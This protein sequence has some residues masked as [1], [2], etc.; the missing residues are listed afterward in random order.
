MTMLSSFASSTPRGY[1]KTIIG[2][3][4]SA[5]LLAL[6]RPQIQFGDSGKLNKEFEEG[7][8]DRLQRRLQIDVGGADHSIQHVLVIQADEETL[9]KARH[10]LEKELGLEE[11]LAALKDANTL[12]R[13]KNVT[14]DD[15]RRA[16]E[17]AAEVA[18]LLVKKASSQT[19]GN[20][21]KEVAI[22]ELDEDSDITSF[23]AC[24]DMPVAVCEQMIRK[25]LRELGL[26]WKRFKL[27]KHPKRRRDAPGYNKVVIQTDTLAETV[28]VNPDYPYKWNGVDGNRSIGPWICIGLTPE[29][30][31]NSIKEDV[32]D[33]NAADPGVYVECEITVPV[34]GEGNSDPKRIIINESTDGRV[35]EV[36][37]TG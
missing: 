12:L 26:P 22:A 20:S 30:C 14:P 6:L 9:L 27:E 19:R 7:G 37:Q 24:E 8:A 35:H 17:L 21:G 3:L 36:P 29:T 10:L 13:K 33:E 34:G 5:A 25:G 28:A 31:C 18:R 11:G 32:P 1:R 15:E 16:L 4:G 2:L 23:P